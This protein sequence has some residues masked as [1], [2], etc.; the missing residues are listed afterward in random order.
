M[1]YRFRKRNLGKP[2]LRS[3]E[4]YSFCYYLMSTQQKE[5]VKPV[6]FAGGRGW[7]RTTEVG[8]DR[9]TV[10]SLWPLGN[11]PKYSVCFLITQKV[12]IKK[13]ELVNGI[14]PSTY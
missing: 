1:Y 4:R 9:F 11:P 5:Q 14:E 13:M 12:L 3:V 6:P 2:S 7:I 8:D 10:C